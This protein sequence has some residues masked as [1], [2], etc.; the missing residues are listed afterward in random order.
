[1]L[2]LGVSSHC[3]QGGVMRKIIYTS[4]AA[5]MLAPSIPV[6]ANYDYSTRDT[7]ATDGSERRQ[8]RR[9]DGGER[10]DDRRD[11]R[12]AILGS[13]RRQERRDD[14]QERRGDRQ[15]RRDDRRN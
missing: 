3:N 4:L 6:I 11:G 7:V 2:A 10:R 1:M 13:E 8:E 5:L 9:D 12:V 14:R 15:E